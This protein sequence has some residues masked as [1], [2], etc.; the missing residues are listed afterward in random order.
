MSEVWT[1]PSFLALTPQGNQGAGAVAASADVKATVTKRLAALIGPYKDAVSQQGPNAARMQSLMGAVTQHITQRNF[2]QAAKVLDAL[3]PLIGPSKM[4]GVQA[5]VS[6]GATQAAAPANPAPGPAGALTAGEAVQRDKNAA[7]LQRARDLGLKD[8]KDRNKAHVDDLKTWPEVDTSGLSANEASSRMTLLVELAQAYNAG[9][10]AG[11]ASGGA[12]TSSTGPVA[13]AGPKSPEPAAHPTAKPPT[14]A[15][16]S[17]AGALTAGEAVERDK[18]A[19]ALKLPI[20][21]Q[22]VLSTGGPDALKSY[23]EGKARPE[24]QRTLP[25]DERNVLIAGGSDGLT[26]YQE[27]KFHAKLERVLPVD[28]KNVLNAGGESALKSYQAGKARA[29]RQQGLPVDEQ[30]VLHTG[31]SDALESYQ[32]GK[33][34]SPELQEAHR[35]YKATGQIPQTKHAFAGIEIMEGRLMSRAERMDAMLKAKGWQYPDLEPATVRLVDPAYLTD[36]EYRAETIQRAKDERDACGR[37]S[38][39]QVSVD[40]KYGGPSFKESDEARSRQSLREHKE[41]LEDLQN[42]G[43]GGLAGKAV[44]KGVCRPIGGL[45]GGD[46]GAEMAEKTCEAAGSLADAALLA[47]AGH[48]A[49]GRTKRYEDPE[50]G[51]TPEPAGAGPESDG[52]PVE[53]IKVLTTRGPVEMTSIQISVEQVRAQNWLQEQ[54][55]ADSKR[56]ESQRRTEPQLIQEARDEFNIDADWEPFATSEREITVQTPRGPVRM[57]VADYRKRVEKAEQWVHDVRRMSRGEL[58]EEDLHRE[59]AANFGLDGSWADITNPNYRGPRIP[60]APP[61][62]EPVSPQRVRQMRYHGTAVIQSPS[63]AAHQELWATLGHQDQAPIA[64]VVDNQIHMDM[65]RWPQDLPLEW[66]PSGITPRK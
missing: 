16:P 23:Q 7:A 65:S 26:G 36:D 21:E 64:Y 51:G 29:E 63:P 56:P 17:P 10:A 6:N 13:Q 19:A 59:A 49:M 50:G 42:T 14:A 32:Q 45:I 47:K 62:G 48:A 2:E 30:N 41:H 43:A 55:T 61:R 8:G 1:D 37:N 52:V 11:T 46:E 39:C 40:N 20:D 66:D 9:W 12:T 34:L 53:L 25:L 35:V 44:G 4:P 60:P 58:S 5:I 54:M 27:G 28:E 38:R 18:K 31:G 33:A 15:A 24:W 3:E 22:N 57:T